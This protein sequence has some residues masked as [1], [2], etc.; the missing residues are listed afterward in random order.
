TLDEDAKNSICG[1]ALNQDFVSYCESK[2][3]NNSNHTQILLLH[4]FAGVN[5]EQLAQ[6]IEN[7]KEKNYTFVSLSEALGTDPEDAC[8]AA[9]A[10]SQTPVSSTAG[11]DPCEGACDD[12]D[13]SVCRPGLWQPSGGASYTC[14]P[15]IPDYSQSAQHWC[16]DDGDCNDANSN[17]TTVGKSGEI[18]YGVCC[19]KDEPRCWK[20][21]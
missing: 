20:R 2:I 15:R 12:N 4:H 6:L 5:P 21:L 9:T 10:V 13:G 8:G 16:D 3:T 17:C 18:P 14:G 19:P 11:D 1:N 7:L